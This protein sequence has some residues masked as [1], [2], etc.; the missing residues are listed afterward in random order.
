M[1]SVGFELA[2]NYH[3]LIFLVSSVF[4]NSPLFVLLLYRTSSPV[5]PTAPNIHPV[6]SRYKDEELFGKLDA[7]DTAWLCASGFITE[8]QTFYITTDDGTS[9]TCQVIHSAVG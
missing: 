3:V 5:D 4:S 9:I 8:T 1:V 2:D 7:N 6:S